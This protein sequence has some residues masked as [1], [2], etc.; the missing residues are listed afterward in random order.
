MKSIGGFSGSIIGMKIHYISKSEASLA[1]KSE[2]AYLV[3]SAPS[4]A[5][6]REFP[7]HV[8]SGRSLRNFMM[9][10]WW[11]AD[12]FRCLLSS[13]FAP[14]FHS[15]VGGDLVDSSFLLLQRCY[16]VGRKSAPLKISLAWRR[17]SYWV[18][19]QSRREGGMLSFRRLFTRRKNGQ[20]Q[21]LF[22]GFFYGRYPLSSIHEPKRD[23]DWSRQRQP[24]LAKGM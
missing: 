10:I 2:N 7:I 14:R 17:L 22:I 1:A 6:Q 16:N 13:C 5:D 15:P 11:L 23:F 9:Y 12:Q 8:F 21:L 20:S 24:L 4:S 18:R 19:A 3:G